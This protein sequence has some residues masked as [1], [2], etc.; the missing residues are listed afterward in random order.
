MGVREGYGGGG[1]V[2]SSKEQMEQPTNERDV[3]FQT[4]RQERARE[5]NDRPGEKR[6]GVAIPTYSINLTGSCGIALT[7]GRAKDKS[8]CV[9]LQIS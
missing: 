9:K 2:S 3:H 7:K 4:G 8:V 5:E 6:G 1:R